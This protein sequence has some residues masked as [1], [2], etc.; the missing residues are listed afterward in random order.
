M[1]LKD[2]KQGATKA[3]VFGYDRGFC[4]PPYLVNLFVMKPLRQQNRQVISYV[5]RVEPAPP[6]HAVKM[7]GFRD[8][9]VLR[10]KYVAFVLIDERFR[11]SPAFNVPEAAQRWA[12]QMRQEGEIDA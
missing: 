4:L 11:R 2:R 3:G 6:E 10:G 7:D 1:L 9:W 8:V 12:T 5:P